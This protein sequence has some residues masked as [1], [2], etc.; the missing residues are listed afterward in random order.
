MASDVTRK[1][2]NSVFEQLKLE[3]IADLTTDD[4]YEGFHPNPIG[5]F[6]QKGTTLPRINVF[7]EEAP[8]DDDDPESG[9]VNA[10][11]NV[12]VRSNAHDNSGDQHG[13]RVKAVQDVLFQNPITL[14]NLLTSR[15]TDFSVLQVTRSGQNQEVDGDTMLTTLA[16]T[17][18]CLESD[19]S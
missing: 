14:S 6:G 17:L 18:T 12:E 2:Q 11:V 15:V 13:S 1:A 9:V 3:T 5:F 19:L 8:P 16:I 4:I 7:C 10:L